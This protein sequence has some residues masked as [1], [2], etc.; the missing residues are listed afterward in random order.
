MKM[1]RT[2]QKAKTY[3]HGDLRQALLRSAESILKREGLKALSLRAT[4]RAAGV[5]H[6]APAHH[7]PDLSSLLSALAAE[8]FERL[9]DALIQAANHGGDTPLELAKTYIT[10]AKTNPALFQLMS[11]PNR[12]DARNP[13]LQSARKRS[14]SILAGTR[15][16]DI[17]N[18]TLSQVGAMTAN[19]ALIHGLALLLLTGRLGTLVRMAPEGTTE[20]DLIQAAINSMRRPV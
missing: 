13:A 12:L 7:F 8:G 15:G 6:A 3:H 18:P 10:F 9:A 5:S 4:A 14:I 1:N 2:S 11:D 20:M 16:A 17:E 19:W